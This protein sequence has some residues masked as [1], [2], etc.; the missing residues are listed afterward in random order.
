MLIEGSMKNIDREKGTF[1]SSR[2]VLSSMRWSCG[3][4][5]SEAMR[6]TVTATST[7]TAQAPGD[8]R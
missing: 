2:T 4:D 7:L 1:C 3:R 5:L 6:S 8:D